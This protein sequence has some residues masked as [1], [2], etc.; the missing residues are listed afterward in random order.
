M[1]QAPFLRLAPLT[2]EQRKIIAV[3]AS[4]FFMVENPD[5]IYKILGKNR[6]SNTIQ[7]L[8]GFEFLTYLD[9]KGIL[10]EARRYQFV[11]GLLLDALEATGWLTFMGLSPSTMLPKTYY[12][13]KQATRIERQ[14]LYLLAQP[15]GIDFLYELIAP[16]IVHITGTTPNGDVHAGTGMFITEN[17]ILT[18]AH[19]IDDMKLDD[20]LTVNGMSIQV[21]K[22]MSHPEIDVGL[23]YLDGQVTTNTYALPFV[24]PQ[25]GMNVAILGYPKIPIAKTAPL[26]LQKGE[27]TC[28]E[29]YTYFNN[30]LFLFSAIARPGNS[31]G[32]I[33]ST[34]GQF[35]GLVSQDV[36]L[37]DKQEDDEDE[38]EME[39]YLQEPMDTNSRGGKR[40]LDDKASRAF[41]P[42]YCGIPTT[43]VVR[44][45]NDLDPTIVLP[46]EEYK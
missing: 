27:V 7:P 17:I 37:K 40:P 11:I 3:A 30:R 19:V 42:H 20:A 21:M 9:A 26:T 18:C 32:P 24:D 45:V 22:A 5:E 16:N 25:I 38:D 33:L 34:N 35:L 28:A 15:L 8:S 2:V 1:S 39:Q 44:A 41:A 46:V 6:N 29:M 13:M 36:T 12:C 43:E 4:K 10:P 23:I 31:G 14:G